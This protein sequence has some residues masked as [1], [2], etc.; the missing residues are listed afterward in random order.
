[1]ASEHWG[2]VG[3]LLR[4]HGVDARGIAIAEKYYMDA[5]KHGYKHGHKAGREY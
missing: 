1:M 2:Y 5:F 4:F 3:E